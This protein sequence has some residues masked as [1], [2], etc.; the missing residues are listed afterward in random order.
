MCQRSVGLIHRVI[1]AQGIPSVTVF[2][3]LEYAPMAP[4]GVHVR[5]PYG[6]PIGE[7]NNLERQRQVI[8]DALGLLESATEPGTVVELPYRWRRE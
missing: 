2:N 6:H 1:E 8:L 3:T 4:R 5:F 7:A